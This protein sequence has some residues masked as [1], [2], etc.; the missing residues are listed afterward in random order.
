MATVAVN[1]KGGYRYIEGVFQYS[2]GVAAEPGYRIERVRFR[3]PLALREGFREIR[4]YLDAIGRPIHAFCACE[5]RSPK[6]FDEAAFAAFNREYVDPLE[7]W[8]VFRDDKN[9]IARTNVCPVIEAPDAPSFHA[10]SYTVESQG[11]DEGGFIVAGSAEAPEGKGS[12]RDHT[13]RLGDRSAEGLKEKALWVC[14]EM[15]RR[16]A[17]LGFGWKDATD[18]GLYTMFDV[19]PFLE[20]ILARRLGGNMGL[21]WHYSRPPVN[22]LDYEMDTRGV[23]R[24]LVL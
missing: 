21:D 19:H 15:E 6:P 10:F 16:M 12:Y 4:N 13:I 9:P 18:V 8:G 17:L 2:G 24:N 7:N 14:E 1:P 23:A 3:R 11:R 5:L 22:Y 20:E